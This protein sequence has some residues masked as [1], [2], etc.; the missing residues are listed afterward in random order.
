MSNWYFPS[1]KDAKGPKADIFVLQ[2]LIH[3]YYCQCGKE[4]ELA[5]QDCR[6]MWLINFVCRSIIVSMKEFFPKPDQHDRFLLITILAFFLVFLSEAEVSTVNNSLSDSLFHAAVGPRPGS[7]PARTFSPSKKRSMNSPSKSNFALKSVNFGFP[8]MT[9]TT[10]S[11]QQ[12][13]PGALS[14][15]PV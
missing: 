2:H 6:S 4:A 14:S 7:K 15:C 11:Q 10:N 13:N 1:F 3:R 8:M 12:R 5:Q 9:S